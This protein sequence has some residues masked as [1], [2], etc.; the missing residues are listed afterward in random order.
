MSPIHCGTCHHACDCRERS[1]SALINTAREAVFELDNL[2]SISP[3]LTAAHRAAIRALVERTYAA[4]SEL[5]GDGPDIRLPDP[6]LATTVD[7]KQI[8]RTAA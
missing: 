5:G 6:G 4:C 8:E 2:Q 3:V 7:G 1:I